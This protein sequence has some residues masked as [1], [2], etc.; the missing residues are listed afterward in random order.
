MYFWVMLLTWILMTVVLH[1]YSLYQKIKN[2]NKRLKSSLEENA[3]Q[4][5]I[6]VFVN[7]FK[8]LKH[9]ID[10]ISQVCNTH[11]TLVRKIR[12]DN[13]E[14][15]I[16]I[17]NEKDVLSLELFKL[18]EKLH[19]Y[20]QENTHQTWMSNGLIKFDNLMRQTLSIKDMCAT[21][22]SNLVQYLQVQQGG[23]LLLTNNEYEESYLELV[24]TFAYNKQ[25]SLEKKIEIGAGLIGQVFLDKQTKLLTDIPPHWKI[26]SA[27]G[28]TAPRSILIVP[29]KFYEEVIGILELSS[30]DMF[31]SHHIEF[32]EKVAEQVSV[33][34]FR[35][36]SNEQTKE[37][38]RKSQEQAEELQAREEEIRSNLD[39]LQAN[40]EEIKTKN[41]EI[42]QIHSHL[43]SSIEAALTIQQ[44][45]LPSAE[46]VKCLLSDYFILYYPKD[47]VSGDFY[48]IN[49]VDGK[50][51][52]VVADCTGHGVPGAFMSLIGSSLLD[53][54]IFSDKI[55]D[56]AQILY[57]LH[58]GVFNLLK[59][60]ETKNNNGMDLSICVLEKIND[61]QTQMTFV[62]A[63][64]PLFSFKS[65][66]Q[67]L[68]VLKGDRRSIGG[69]Q[70][71]DVPFQN[72]EMML[73][74]GDVIYLSTDGFTDQN[75]L[76]RK[77]FG[78]QSFQEI[79]VAWAK[80]PLHQQKILFDNVLR[81]HMKGTAQRDDIL[82]MGIRID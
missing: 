26:A 41:I 34:I 67:E 54:I 50:T 77:R 44:A 42:E 28:E 24:A 9:N 46:K 51:F 20:F 31:Q 35:Q 23:L 14:S 80:T 19:H 79:I 18:R 38:L 75:N 27:L 36:Q 13:Y 12:D 15:L 82:V 39:Q 21:I 10:T 30:L 76:D 52:V 78:D 2:F 62:G 29:L 72:Q 4:K 8:T 64:R 70:N 25:K 1:Q 58:Q 6:K 11:I 60:A 71:E 37:L 74:K 73:E 47:N 65:Q 40:H 68:V 17:N 43:T 57:Q 32:A 59:Q 22:L 53:K 3:G 16:E 33:T 66:E 61:T 69:I 45:I 81:N 49:Q 5:K 63:K 7:P 55:H 56:P 48:W